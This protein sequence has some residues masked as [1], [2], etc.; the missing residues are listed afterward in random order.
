MTSIWDMSF[1]ILCTLLLQDIFIAAIFYYELLSLENFLLYEGCAK[2]SAFYFIIMAHDIIVSEVGVGTMV[3]A[4]TFL[5]V[6]HSDRISSYFHLFK[7]FPLNSSM[8]KLHLELALDYFVCLFV[9]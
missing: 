3:E 7:S 9:T 8:L 1:E 2:S 4:E 5:P 6:S